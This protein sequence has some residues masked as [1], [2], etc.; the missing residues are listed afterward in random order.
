MEQKKLVSRVRED[1]VGEIYSPYGDYGKAVHV[2]TEILSIK[3]G[4]D[5]TLEGLL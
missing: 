2:T 5:L 3:V 1:I 4:K